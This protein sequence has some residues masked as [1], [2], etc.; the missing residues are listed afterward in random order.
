MGSDLP[1][2]VT[3]AVEGDQD[4][5]NQIVDAMDNMVWSVVRS[6]RLSDADSKDAAQMVWLR[7]LE[8]LHK[9]R[10]PERL[11]LWIATTSRRECMRL[12]EKQSR[13]V[14]TDHD[15]GFGRLAA[16]DDVEHEQ[17]DRAEARRLIEAIQSLGTDCQQLLRLVLC[18][19]PMSYK[20][21]SAALG[22]AVGTIGA[23]RQRCLSRLR[24]AAHV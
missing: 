22:I 18:D 3:A 12:I 15:K 5:W 8:G 23:R 20:E 16:P 6:F 4:A 9:V 24:A 1:A 11:G 2:L 21:I 10:D 17:A 7:V 13:M 14:P 19:P